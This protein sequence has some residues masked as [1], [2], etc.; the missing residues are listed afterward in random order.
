[1]AIS[2]KAG[3]AAMIFIVSVGILMILIVAVACLAFYQSAIAAGKRASKTR[4]I[5]IAG[6]LSIVIGIVFYYGPLHDPLNK[7]EGVRLIK[8]HYREL[9]C[10]DVSIV[11]SS[12]QTH[13]ATG[14]KMYDFFV[15]HVKACGAVQNYHYDVLADKLYATD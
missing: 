2:G 4:F 9:A 7:R 11:S 13:F 1:M 12:H 15:Y 8:A 5:M 10:E 3:E 6:A 14:K